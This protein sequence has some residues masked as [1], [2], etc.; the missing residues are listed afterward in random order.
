MR[1]FLALLSLAAVV[2]LAGCAPRSSE[3]SGTSGTAASPA[4]AAAPAESTPAAPATTLREKSLYD[5]GPRANATAFDPKL[6]TQGEQLFKTKGCPVCHAWGK[7]LQGP[8][9]KGVTAQ[10]TEEWMR[11]QMMEPLVMT[12]TDPISHQLMVEHK[13]LQMLDM[14]LS[15]DEADALINY[16][17]KLDAGK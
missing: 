12:R 1:P 10:R 13:N 3:N 11:H 5:D 14:H 6:A 2:I 17:K 4:P 16:L 15:R 9:L 7:T 8:D